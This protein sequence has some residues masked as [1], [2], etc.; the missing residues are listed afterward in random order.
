VPFDLGD[1]ARLTATCKDAGGTATN[2]VGATLTIGLPDGTTATPAIT[3]PPATTGQYS[4]DYVTTQAG[5]HSIRWVFTG[6]ACAYTDVLDVREAAPPLLF[7]LAAAKAKLDIPA[8]STGDDEELREFIEATTQ[9]VEYFVG[10]VARRTVQQIVR[11]GGYS[12]VLHTHPVLAVASVVGIQS[13][14]LPIEV[15]ALDIDPDTGIVRRSDILPFWPGEYRI[16]YTAG[17]AA[18]PANVSLAAKLILQHLWRT[19]FGA[20]RG[21]SSS[22][23]YNVTEQVPGFGYAIPNRAL[24]LLQGDRQLE[25]FA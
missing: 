14:Q 3:N 13:W 11:G 16:T 24:Q 9:C 8:T 7:S 5:R 18:V 6:P 12:V 10:P 20:A 21:P 2:A 15:S 22:D 25:G 4:Y 19:N 1:T 23:D 17:R